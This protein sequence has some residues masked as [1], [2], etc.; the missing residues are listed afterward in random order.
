MGSYRIKEIMF[1]DDDEIVKMVGAKVLQRIN[2]INEISY[3]SNGLEALENILYRINNSQ[4]T[5]D[6]DPVLIL[7]DI[8]MPKMNAWEF[9]NEFTLLVPE[10]KNK[11]KIV[12]VTSSFNP[13]DKIKAFSYGEIEDYT[14]KPLSA[15][16]FKDFLIKHHYYEE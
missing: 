13:E 9:M 4:I 16:L 6:S 1:I 3:F 14:N 8:N 10:M 7:L 11:F 5:I 15:L 2:Y 12:I